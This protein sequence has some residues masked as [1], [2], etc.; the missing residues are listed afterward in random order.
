LVIS[1]SRLFRNTNPTQNVKAYDLWL[2]GSYHLKRKDFDDIKKAMKFFKRAIK[3]DPNY[4]EAYAY[5]G[6]AYIHAASYNMLPNQ[7]GNDL[8]RNAA[9]K[10]I[11]LNVE[12]AKAHMML[13]YI[14]LFSD[15]N[16][17]AAL[18]NTIRQ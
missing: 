10:A 3:V 6:E 4:A 9:E 17:D 13:A 1:K 12:N 2:K 8:A 16:W 5:L 15:W 7:E 11:E 14:K 18:K